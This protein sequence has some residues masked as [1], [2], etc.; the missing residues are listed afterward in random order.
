MAV[1]EDNQGR[2]GL[3]TSVELLGAAVGREE[4]LILSPTLEGHGHGL[5][6]GS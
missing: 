6:A 2:R 4:E 3:G 5:A 1:S